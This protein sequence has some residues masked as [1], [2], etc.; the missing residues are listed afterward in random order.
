[1]LQGE[2]T[3]SAEALGCECA[4]CAQASARR[5][6]C[7]AKGGLGVR[8]EEVAR[9]ELPRGLWAMLGTLVEAGE[10]HAQL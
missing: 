9:S 4:R 1:M 3:A 5:P 10:W 2:I 6:V 8:L 7:Q